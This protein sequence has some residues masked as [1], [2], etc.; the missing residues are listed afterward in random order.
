VVARRSG[1]RAELEG[2]NVTGMA[3][4]PAEKQRRY[5]ERQSAIMRD[6]PDVAE[7]ALLKRRRGASS[8]RLS[9]ASLWRTSWRSWRTAT[10]GVRRNWLN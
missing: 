6:N 1:W 3:L 9:S 8:C 2:G 5:R 7:R 4:S 10:C